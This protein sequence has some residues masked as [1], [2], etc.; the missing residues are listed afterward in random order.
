MI[1]KFEGTAL[2]LVTVLF[3]GIIL[4]L[5]ISRFSAQTI[6]RIS[7]SDTAAIT[8]SSTDVAQTVAAGMLNINLATAKEFAMLPGI[9]EGLAQRIVDYRLENGP[10]I[11][12]NDLTNVS[13]IG[14]KRLEE[15]IDY[16]TVG[17]ES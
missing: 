4:G 17:G 7:P 10:F 2:I 8:E 11:S 14:Q 6:V 9:G 15:I 16:I 5:L 12:V 3:L 13:G 1:K